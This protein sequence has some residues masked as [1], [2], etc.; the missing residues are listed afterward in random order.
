M[1]S[2]QR[3]RE[4]VMCHVINTYSL[5]GEYVL[6]I[7]HIFSQHPLLLGQYI[8]FFLVSQW[9]V[10]SSC[11]GGSFET[12]I[13]KTYSPSHRLW[14]HSHLT[15]SSSSWKAKRVPVMPMLS[16][17]TGTS[18]R[19]FWTSTSRSSQ[20]ASSTKPATGRAS[21]LSTTLYCRCDPVSQWVQLRYT[22]ALFMFFY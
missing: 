5:V 8:Q 18:N 21:K 2:I 9:C 22:P 4:Y 6:Y 7:H 14:W 1:P 12:L 3:W 16:T 13:S 20:A 10:P 17:C 15:T 11:W 19:L